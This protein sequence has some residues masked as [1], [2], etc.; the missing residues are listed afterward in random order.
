VVV[1]K[2]EKEAL[3]PTQGGSRH[4][5]ESKEGAT[6][7]EGGYSHWVKGLLRLRGRMWYT[8]RVNQFPPKGSRGVKGTQ[9]QPSGKWGKSPLI[10]QT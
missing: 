9:Y 1:A 5:E 4:V 7:E 8:S 10:H 2:C 3:R 6:K